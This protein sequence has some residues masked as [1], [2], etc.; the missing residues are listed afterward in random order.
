MIFL[1]FYTAML[2]RGLPGVSGVVACLRGT[3]GAY[4]IEQRYKFIYFS[5]SEYS[6]YFLVCYFI[7]S[8]D[9][10]LSKLFISSKKLVYCINFRT[11]MIIFKNLVLLDI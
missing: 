9:D 11:I 2:L 4:I 6:R 5:E 3:V 1:P 10:A 8:D 7:F